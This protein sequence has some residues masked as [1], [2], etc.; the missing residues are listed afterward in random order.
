MS[1]RTKKIHRRLARVTFPALA[2]ALI[3]LF[4]YAQMNDGDNDGL[5]TGLKISF[6]HAA[7]SIA[8]TARLGMR[9]PHWR[10]HGCW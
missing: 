8:Y 10:L 7:V 1:P 9:N 5:E 3:G 6:W 4:A 2:L